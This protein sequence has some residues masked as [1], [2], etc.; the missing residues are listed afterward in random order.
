MAETDNSIAQRHAGF[1][2][3]E[4]TIFDLI[5][6]HTSYTAVKR[7]KIVKGYDS[8]VYDIATR[9]GASFIV[10]IK[11]YGELSYEQEA[12]AIEM[13]RNGGIPVPR[14]YALGKVQIE[15]KEREYMVQEKAR[16]QPL[17]DRIERVSFSQ[18]NQI[19][20][21]AG[22]LLR[23]IHQVRAGGFYHR[24]PNTTWDFASWKKLGNST[25]R[26]RAKEKDCLL[27]AGFSQSEVET[28]LHY[29]EVYRDEFTCE[30]PVLCHG[31]YILEHIFLDDELHITAILDFGEFLGN[32]PIHDVAY[33]NAEHPSYPLHALVEGYG[34]HEMFRDRFP[35]RLLLH[36]LGLH[37]G[38]LAHEVR[39]GMRPEAESRTKRLGETLRNLTKSL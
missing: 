28:M 8:E 7:T 10:K 32:H 15:E 13:C 17:V 19:L 27:Q 37:M 2:A 34:D 39:E 23:Q 5:K 38:H 35:E 20:H 25:V 22:E 30:Q 16:G 14:I 3:P 18:I 26:E 29:L 11:H 24:H 6:E 4:E 31:D 33:F 9:E 36:K 12:W 21:R 1:H